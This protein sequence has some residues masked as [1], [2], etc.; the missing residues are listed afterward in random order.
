MEKKNE[1]RRSEET[2]VTYELSIMVRERN[3]WQ[4]FAPTVLC[5]LKFRFLKEFQREPQDSPECVNRPTVKG[6]RQ[7]HCCKRYASKHSNCVHGPTKRSF[8]NLMC[9]KYI[10]IHGDEGSYFPQLDSPL[11]DIPMFFQ[12]LRRTFDCP[13]DDK[14]RHRVQEMQL[15]PNRQSSRPSLGSVLTCYQI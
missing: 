1:L 7:N 5:E 13:N 4:L 11:S 2:L 15:Q 3:G 12:S 6:M 9:W 10:K 8:L 14:I